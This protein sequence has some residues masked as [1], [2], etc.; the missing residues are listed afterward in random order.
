MLL[1]ADK[2]NVSV[3]L[4][5]QDYHE[6][7]TSLLANF[8]THNLSRNPVKNIQNKINEFVKL[9]LNEHFKDLQT[10][11]NLIWNNCTVPRLHGLIKK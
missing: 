3:L 9:L 4:N 7:M 10:N 1:R 8:D 6:K 2:E 11:G 5:K